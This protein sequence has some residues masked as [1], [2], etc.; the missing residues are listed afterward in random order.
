MARASRS[1]PSSRRDSSSAARP[2]RLRRGERLG[3]RTLGSQVRRIRCWP[4]YCVGRFPAGCIGSDALPERVTATIGAPVAQ[5]IE[6][7]TSDQRVG[8]SNPSGRAKTTTCC[9]RGAG[10]PLDLVLWTTS[11]ATPMEVRLWR[12]HLTPS[13]RGHLTLPSQRAGHLILLVG[14][15]G[16]RFEWQFAGLQHLQ[17][18]R[19][20]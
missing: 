3:R 16:I 5:W 11:W 9:G 20:P 6:H 12:E 18:P 10:G 2:A 4:V 14:A 15:M 17:H 7:L 13:I 1:R 8:G 19:G